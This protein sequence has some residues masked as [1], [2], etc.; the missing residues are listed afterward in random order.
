MR[1][2]PCIPQ[3][4]VKLGGEKFH[5]VAPFRSLSFAQAGSLLGVLCPSPACGSLEAFYFESKVNKGPLAMPFDRTVLPDGVMGLKGRGRAKFRSSWSGFRHQ[6][7]PVLTLQMGRAWRSC[8]H[9]GQC[10]QP[11]SGLCLE[12]VSAV[13]CGRGPGEREMGKRICCDYLGS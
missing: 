3:P 8:H 13:A 11:I 10:R 1:E 9:C 7:C 5:S 6:P 2:A 12:G 4:I